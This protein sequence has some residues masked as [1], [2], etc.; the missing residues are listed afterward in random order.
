MS[1]STTE[2][3]LLAKYGPL[4]SL[5][6]LAGLLNRSVD[7]LR[8]SLHGTSAFSR[9]IAA[10]KIRLGRRIYF[11]TVPVAQIISGDVEKISTSETNME[12]NRC[13]SGLC[14]WCS[15]SIRPEAAKCS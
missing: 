5:V 11:R 6:Q 3:F 14:L 10:T 4:L 9:Q 1:T 2:E 8:M 12:K 15:I 13:P 7:G